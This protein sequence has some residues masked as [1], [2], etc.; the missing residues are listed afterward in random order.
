MPPAIL[1]VNAATARWTVLPVTESQGPIL[2]TT[3]S[4]LTSLSHS[5]IWVDIGRGDEGF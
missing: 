2:A 3:D 1:R 5:R 4:R